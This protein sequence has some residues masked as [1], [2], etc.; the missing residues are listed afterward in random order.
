MKERP[1]LFSGAMVRAIMDGRKTMTRRVVKGPVCKIFEGVPHKWKGPCDAQPIRCPYGQPGDRLWVRETFHNSRGD[2]SMPTYYQADQYRWG[3]ADPQY[4]NGPWKPSIFMP[5]WASRITLEVT[6]VRAERLREIT[7]ADARAE[8][9]ESTNLR[10]GGCKNPTNA[11]PGNCP[12]GC[13]CFN[14][15]ENFA[16]LW[17]GINGERGYGWDVNPRVWVVEFRRV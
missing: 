14:A 4:H 12:E 2:N 17:D 13:N 11:K 6:G 7:E 8:G 1:I 15:R 3:P 5:R 9:A 16:G 10:F